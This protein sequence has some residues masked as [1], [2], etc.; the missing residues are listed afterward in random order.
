MK[1]P[2]AGSYSKAATDSSPGASGS[3]PYSASG[4][5]GTYSFYTRAVDGVGNYETA[6]GAAD[7]ATLLDTTPPQ[8]TITS[9]PSS[10]TNDSTPTFSFSSS[11]GGSTFEC[12]VDAAAFAACTS[13]YTSA[14][15]ADGAHTFEVR[16]KDG[17]GNTDGSPAV[18]SFTVDTASPVSHAESTATTNSTTITVSYTASDTGSGLATV[19][20]WVKPPGAGSYSKAATDSTP[21]ASESFLYGAS[22]GDGTYSFYTRATDKAGNYEAAPDAADSTSLVDTTPPQTTITPAPPNFTNDSTPSFSFSSNEGGSSFQC[23][24]DGAGFSGCTSPYTSAALGDGAH[25]FE[26]RAVDAAGNVDPT[27]ATASFTVDTASPVSHAESTAT[28]NSTSISVSYTASDSGGSGLA[29]VEL[30]VKPPGAGSYSKAATDSSP[31]ASGSFPYSASGGDGTYSFYTRAVDGVGNYETAPGAADAA[32]LLDTTPPQTTITSAPSS[33]TNDSTPTFS[34]SSSEGGSTFEC[35]VDA[36]AFAACTSSY[37]SAALADGA[38]TFEV[39]AKDGAGNTD[40]SPAVSSFTVDTASPV[41]HAESTATTNSTTI[42]V[43]YTASDTGSG[44]A[45]VEL[46]V[47]PPG[48]RQLLQSRHRQHALGVGVVPLRRLLRRWHLQLLHAGDRQSRQ[49]RGGT[50]CGGLHNRAGHE[51][52]GH[53]TAADHDRLRSTRSHQRLDADLQFFLERVGLDLRMQARWRQL[54]R[55][56]YRPTPLRLWKMANT[57][58]KSG[59]RIRP[60]TPMERPTKRS[61]RWT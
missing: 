18:S 54:R 14:A 4:G 12:R 44:L 10:P 46:W 21:S 7:A 52:S 23:S 29:S 2:G 33:P 35:R 5:D 15:L 41:S 51:R 60:I 48:R 55:M 11:E 6:P 1:P 34:F 19:E 53:G 16:A 57:P 28:T 56:R 24:V 38:H 37:T 8:T 30:W 17:A 31:G 47:K 9:A 32:T 61:S 25:K 39:R 49:L 20:L 58:S 42:T 43:S 13:S 40:G 3:F 26:V 45:T 22:S 27:P 59:P 36:A 50:R